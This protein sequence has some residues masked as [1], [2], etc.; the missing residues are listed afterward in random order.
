MQGEDS[1]MKSGQVKGTSFLDSL[2]A[3]A[4]PRCVDL[5]A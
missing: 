5:N 4:L 3:W 1:L 2:S